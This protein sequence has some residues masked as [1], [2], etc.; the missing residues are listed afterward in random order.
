MLWNSIQA[1]WEA[2]ILPPI[3]IKSKNNGIEN[4]KPPQIVYTVI[5]DEP[6]LKSNIKDKSISWFMFESWF[7]TPDNTVEA[8]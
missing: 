5:E 2:D 1:P 6:I 3:P 7:G 4:P 8:Q